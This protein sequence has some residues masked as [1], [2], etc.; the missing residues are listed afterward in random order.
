MSKAVKKIILSNKQAEI[1]EVFLSIQGEGPET[2]RPS[3]FVRLSGCNLYCFWCDTPYTWNWEDTSYPHQELKKYKKKHQQILLTAEKLLQ[4]INKYNCNNIVFTGG[5]PLLQRRALLAICQGLNTNHAWV[6]DV[7]TNATLIPDT[8][9]DCFISRYVCSPKLANS[10]IPSDQRIKENALH[11]FS[12]CNKACFKFVVAKQA[13]FEEL[14]KIVNKFS[15]N[16]D[17]VYLM[18]QALNL[19][20]LGARGKYLADKCLDYGYRYSDR[21]HYRLYGGGRGV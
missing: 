7:E 1:P 21:L 13:D 16:K 2:G 3:I 8:A 12:N 14:E 9:L 19:N 18:S 10:R 20:E 5:E 17:R 11:W 15:I 6:I 4:E